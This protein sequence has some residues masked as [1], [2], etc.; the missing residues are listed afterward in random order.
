MI[1]T[2]RSE[3]RARNADPQISSIK[4]NKK[5]ARHP[6]QNT[7]ESKTSG[8]DVGLI[9]SEIEEM[10]SNDIREELQLHG[11]STTYFT[12]KSGLTKSL[13]KVRLGK[14]MAVGNKASKGT[15]TQAPQTA[16]PKRTKS[17]EELRNLKSNPE[18]YKDINETNAPNVPNLQRTN[19]RPSYTR[20]SMS[21]SNIAPVVDNGGGRP[22]RTRKN[23][24]RLSQQQQD[25][26]PV[27]LQRNI[28]EVPNTAG[29]RTL[30]RRKSFEE[31]QTARK[32]NLNTTRP[33]PSSHQEA[34]IRPLARRTSLSSSTRSL[35]NRRRQLQVSTRDSQNASINKKINN[36]RLISILRHRDKISI[37]KGRQISNKRVTIAPGRQVHL[38][39]NHVDEEMDL[40]RHSRNAAA[41]NTVESQQYP[42]GNLWKGKTIRRTSTKTFS[43]EAS[44]RT[45]RSVQGHTTRVMQGKQ[46]GIRR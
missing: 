10:N 12:T 22:E 8:I 4:K 34:G 30:I 7:K 23:H 14:A 45:K 42:P 43:V 41:T 31:L 38:V 46:N 5:C 26:Q 2:N 33:N 25:R 36:R 16:Y 35:N 6:T 29:S 13:V 15:P 21:D 18:I 37:A 28:K 11:V 40:M 27:S 19:K 32:I 1:R 44:E 24:P 9:K 17:M 39:P 20:N 3:Q